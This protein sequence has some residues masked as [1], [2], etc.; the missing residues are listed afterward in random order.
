MQDSYI[1]NLFAERIGGSKYGKGSAIYKFEKIKRAKASA[2]EDF[3]DREL[4]DFGIG[5]NDSMAADSVRAALKVEVD[6]P[7]NRGYADNGIPKFK[8]AAKDW[9]SSRLGVELPSLSCVNHCIGTKPALALLPGAFIN[10]GDVTLMTVPGYPVAGNHT[11]FYG[12]EV[13]KLELRA[14]NDF[15]PDLQSIPED[16]ARRA[17]ILLLNY[18]NSPTGALATEGFFKEAI[19]FARKYD[20]IVVNDAAHINL[21]YTG[22][23]LS[24]LSVPGAM[25]VGVETHTMSKGWDMIGWRMGFVAGNE[26]IVRAFADFKD[27]TDSGQFIPIQL[28]AA[29]ALADHSILDKNL[30]KYRRRMQ[31]LVTTLREIGF[32]AE[33]PGGSYFL[34]VPAP[35]GVT[36]GPSFSNAEE[37]SQFLIRERSICT[38]PWDDAGS[39]LRFS[40]T[41][42]AADEVAED[43]QM[44]RLKERLSA[45]SF[46]WN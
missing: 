36:D 1:Q 8:Q 23:P 26:L 32:K 17:K 12:G 15:L 13:Y 14:E 29:K 7:E 31:K 2:K 3:P 22:E 42:Q 39:Y 35:D 10:P 11:G 24:F 38:V 41:Y 4:L 25:E 16:V 9:L 44:S 18:P 43:R 33:M 37:A 34:Y 21:T 19:A 5:E 45:D 30:E 40:L 20:C 27:N 6:K 28:A 46:Y